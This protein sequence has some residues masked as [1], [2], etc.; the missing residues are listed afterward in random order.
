MS[1]VTN[2]EYKKNDN[3]EVTA[4]IYP[5]KQIIE[6]NDR[7]LERLGGSKNVSSE[8]NGTS[9]FEGLGVPVGLY[10]SKKQ[11]NDID[12]LQKNPKIRKECNVIDEEQFDRLL[13]KIVRKSKHRTSAKKRIVPKMRSKKNMK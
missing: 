9:R 1:Y 12:R 8:N 11:I 5:L 10:L 13:E 3:N 4:A 2:F 7:Y 6:E